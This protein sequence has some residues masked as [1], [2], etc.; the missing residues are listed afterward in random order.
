[1]AGSCPAMTIKLASIGYVWI[2]IAAIIR[3]ARP[4]IVF[5]SFAM[6]SMIARRKAFDTVDIAAIT[7]FQQCV[8]DDFATAIKA[9]KDMPVHEFAVDA[10]KYRRI[11]LLALL[12][13]FSDIKMA[14]IFAE[15]ARL[16]VA[17]TVNGNADARSILRSDYD[18]H[19]HIAANFNVIPGTEIVARLAIQRITGLRVGDS[20]AKQKQHK[21]NH[22]SHTECPLLSRWITSLEY[23]AFE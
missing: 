12:W 1:M 2:L 5:L 20:D 18:L 13:I 3:T 14:A 23:R 22:N 16:A 8:T 9:E 11:I 15:D 7:V 19:H 10:N 21:D 6:I 4:P 17:E